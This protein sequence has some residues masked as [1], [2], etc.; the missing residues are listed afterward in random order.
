MCNDDTS[1]RL[2]YMPVQKKV[3]GV[4]NIQGYTQHQQ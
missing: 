2:I 1:V 4:A 3:V